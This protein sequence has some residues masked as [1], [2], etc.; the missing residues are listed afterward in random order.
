MCVVKMVLLDMKGSS[1]T[2][3]A[4][5]ELQGAHILLHPTHFC[6]CAASREANICVTMSSCLQYEASASALLTGDG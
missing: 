1:A 6:W 4:A 3:Y 2:M 5:Y